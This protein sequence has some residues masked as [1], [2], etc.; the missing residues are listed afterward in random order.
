MIG[1]KETRLELGNDIK[2]CSFGQPVLL[3][4]ADS[5]KST[6]TGNGHRFQVGNIVECETRSCNTKAKQESS[7]I[8]P[9]RS[10]Y[11]EESAI[12]DP[13]ESTHLE[14]T[15]LAVDWKA[16]GNMCISRS[17]MGTWCYAL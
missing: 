2:I 10:C 6:S 7:I 8:V 13:D 15:V 17:G 12:S 3:F 9:M 5:H 11:R 14:S 4:G 1:W 16:V